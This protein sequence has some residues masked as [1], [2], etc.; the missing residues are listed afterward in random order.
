VFC[1]ASSLV[2]SA[3]TLQ[4]LVPFDFTDGAY[5]YGTLIQDA[6]GNFYGTTY[7]GGAN[8]E[9]T[10]FEVTPGGT[11]T[12]LYSFC[13]QANCADGAR[14]MAGLAQGIDGNYYGT[15]STGGANSNA[16]CPGSGG[17]GTVFRMTPA[18]KLTTLYS[19]CSTGN[20]TDGIS[21]VSG[22]VQDSAGN[23]YGTTPSG[24]LNVAGTIFEVP[25]GGTLTTL[26]SFCSLA[27]CA[28][29][30]APSAGLLRGTDGNFY[31]TTGSGG[32]DSAGTFFEFLSN[33]TL[34]TLHSF[35]SLENCADGSDPW[36][37]LLQ[38]TDG[39]F[40]GT[41]HTGGANGQ[42]TVYEITPGG[43]L[44]TLY[45]FCSLSKCAD[46]DAPYA[47]LVQ[48]TDGNF[49]GAAYT[50]G[51]HGRGTVF[52]IT[53]GGVLNALYSFCSLSKCADGV[54]PYAGLVQ[55]TDGNFY[56][57]D[58]FGGNTTTG[59]ASGC[60]TIYKF[61]FAGFQVPSFTPASLAFSNQAVD[62][63]S[64]AKSV[65]VK[66]L[67]TGT[68]GFSNI[69]VSGPFAISAN[70]CGP[71]LAA[72]KTCKVSI[73]FT[74]TAP[75]DST[76]A[77]SVYDNATGGTQTVPLSG[78]GLPQ[79]TLTPASL[80]FPT[81]KVGKTSAHKVVTLKSNLLA[82]LTNISYSTTGPFA[83]SG[84]TCATT[85]GYNHSCTISVTFTPTT[86]GPATGSLSVSDSAN[87]SPLTVSL[88]G[89]GD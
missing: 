55:G 14:P 59:C 84:S 74:P 28:D 87:N 43:A 5:S 69:S 56:G 15:T 54:S 37:G 20:C 11:L 23:F 52:Q 12:T 62:T 2:S 21:P 73:T 80:T 46:G 61:S 57:T 51:A 24:G 30:I 45:S 25:A 89:A 71:A 65:T 78:P 38:G 4:T 10:V 79:T 85:L 83:V 34:T 88:S 70:T 17:C 82:D 63:T 53:P 76:G 31:G 29:G 68:L 77:L 18:G 26:Y 67:S 9:G 33:S 72:A 27:N 41:T 58:V 8:S 36:G 50:G 1:V 86:T 7:D 44:N 19:F 47:G 64:I 32:A 66:N 22:L 42:G 60:G 3:Q 49:Y 40:Y 48:G 39:N 81:T 16:M 13:A 35:C 6:D 75:G